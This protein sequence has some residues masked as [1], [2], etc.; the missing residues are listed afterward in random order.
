MSS[1]SWNS[2]LLSNGS[3]FS[4]TPMAELGT[5]ASDT[6]SA[7]AISTPPSSAQRRQARSSSGRNTRSKARG[8]RAA[9]P[10]GSA[11]SASAGPPCWRSS[12]SASQGVTAKAISS[13][14][15]MPMLALMGIGPM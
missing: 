1:T 11:W 9:R 5:S 2:L 15:S 10:V 13:D 14:S 12:L 8:S 7:T 4:T 3:I 6:D